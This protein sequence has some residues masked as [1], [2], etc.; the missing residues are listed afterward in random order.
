MRPTLH[1]PDVLTHT[2]TGINNSVFVLRFNQFFHF[3]IN[4]CVFV[5]SSGCKT[6]MHAEIR[7]F[8]ALL[9]L[10]YTGK[11]TTYKEMWNL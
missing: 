11:M 7:I 1:H 2:Q 4:Q 9:Q 10:Q 8:Y 3:K 5:V 6:I